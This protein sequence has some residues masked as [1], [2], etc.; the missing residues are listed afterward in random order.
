M[1]R[2]QLDAL[3]AG[4]GGVVLITGSAGAGKT[5]LL[6][7]AGG[8]ARAQGI[9]VLQSAGDPAAQAVPFGPILDALVATDDPPVDPARLSELSRSPDQR[10]WLLR[11]LQERLER[12]ALRAPMMIAIDDL[13]WVD[14]G[15]LIA[16]GML[17]RRLAS[18]RILWLFVI[19]RGELSQ[20]AREAV[21]RLEVAGAL[22]IPLD[23]LDDAAVAEI[24]QDLLGGVPDTALLQALGRADGQPFLLVE[25][26]RGL[27]DEKLVEIGHGT[28]RLAGT[29][30][31]R[32][33]VEAVGEHLRR[34]PSEARDAVEMASVLGRRFSLDELAALLSRPALELRGTL[35]QAIDA[36]LIVEDG[37]R[38]GFR[39]DLVREAVDAS[40][41]QAI[42]RSVRR[43][44]VEV[45]LEH[46]APAAD[47]ALLVMDIAEPG[48]RAAIELLRQAAAEIGR[49]SPS[50]AAPLSRRAL[51]LTP[52]G[53]PARGALVV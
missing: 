53:D 48:D 3:R 50:V 40:L 31:P 23:R 49:L 42:R 24:A 39:H 35:R 21:Q 25:L 41:P 28:V 1:L 16:L 26:L 13:Q 17:P 5:T 47:V 37:D 32:R 52:P 44:A 27:R 22:E 20:S 7:E 10:F 43:R 46:G 29:Q 18:H 12:A 4:R 6:A 15:T 36:G 38:L 33:F 19:R 11:E 14:A 34:L 2:Q 8:L 45:M 30:L 9:R 51:D